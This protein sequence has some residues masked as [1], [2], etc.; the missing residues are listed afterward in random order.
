MQQRGMRGHTNTRIFALLGLVHKRECLSIRV[1]IIEVCGS[2]QTNRNMARI[3]CAF[4]AFVPLQWPS[5]HTH[6]T[7]AYQ[8]GFES[9]LSFGSFC[10]QPWESEMY[11]QTQ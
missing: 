5:G 3:L 8:R 11:T 6:L 9:L 4:L 2:Q 1:T 7:Y 10:F